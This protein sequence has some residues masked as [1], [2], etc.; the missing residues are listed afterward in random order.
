V[1]PKGIVS[2]KDKDISERGVHTEHVTPLT[3]VFHAANHRG[4]SKQAIQKYEIDV[5]LNDEKVEAR[6]PYYKDGKHVA[7]KI[8]TKDKKFSW[9][10]EIRNSAT[11]LNYSV[12][13]CSSR[14][15]SN[16][17]RRRRI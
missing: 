10:Y 15:K 13:T 1:P 17:S 5:V 2:N 16:Y 6:Y 4:I 7:N 12:S 8:R 9:E 11:R 3:D 14:T